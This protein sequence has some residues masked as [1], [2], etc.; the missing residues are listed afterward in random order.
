MA[1]LCSCCPKRRQTDTE[2]AT[3]VIDAN[4][5]P[6]KRTKTNP[7][8]LDFASGAMWPAGPSGGQAELLMPSSVTLELTQA[9]IRYPLI[10]D[11]PPGHASRGPIL[12]VLAAT[13][14][15][16]GQCANRTDLDLVLN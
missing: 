5:R 7:G 10:L 1:L 13:M 12:A 2:S 3:G 8:Q 9:L 16:H 14:V 15:S 6:A 11:R 4:F